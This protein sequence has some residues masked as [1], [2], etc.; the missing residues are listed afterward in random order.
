MRNNDEELNPTAARKAARRK[1]MA[2]KRAAA[3]EKSL[4]NGE[5][6]YTEVPKEK[7]G[8]SLR[9]K[10]ER[11]KSSLSS[12][13]EDTGTVKVEKEEKEKVSMKDRLSKFA[14]SLTPKKEKDSSPLIIET[15]ETN[16][17]TEEVTKEVKEE[18]EETVIEETPVESAAAESLIIKE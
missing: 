8:I 12:R 11:F 15:D 1:I 2:E 5:E 4:E 7:D 18:K 10:V 14:A 6:N 17:V 3:K 16:T 9:E 13:K